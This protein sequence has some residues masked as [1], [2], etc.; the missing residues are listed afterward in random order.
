MPYVEKY[1]GGIIRVETSTREEQEVAAQ[2]EEQAV[3]QLLKMHPFFGIMS[4]M[5]DA[6]RRERTRKV[7]ILGRGVHVAHVVDS[8]PDSEHVNPPRHGSALG[9]LAAVNVYRRRRET[10]N[11]FR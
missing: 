3:Q 1:L 10:G 6:L 8:I 11:P 5:P 7:F 9:F 4:G 2:V